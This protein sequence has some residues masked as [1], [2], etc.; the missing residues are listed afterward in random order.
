MSKLTLLSISAQVVSFRTAV[1]Q[2]SVLIQLRGDTWF[3]QLL[4]G[5]FSAQDFPVWSLHHFL[6]VELISGSASNIRMAVPG[7]LDNICL[8]VCEN[9]SGMALL[10]LA[11]WWVARLV[12]PFNCSWLLH[13]FVA[14]HSARQCWRRLKEWEQIWFK[15]WR[16]NWRPANLWLLLLLVFYNHKNIKCCTVQDLWCW[17]EARLNSISH[18]SLHISLFIANRSL[19]HLS[20]CGAFVCDRHGRC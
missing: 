9:T 7:L 11:G 1:S 10:C 19:H 5:Q 14:D 6:L 18:L 15:R 12:A 20:P 13:H 17:G 4:P 16:N 8:C 2:V 3:L